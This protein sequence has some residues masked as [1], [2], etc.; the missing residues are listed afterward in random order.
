[1]SLRIFAVLSVLLLGL[2]GQAA[3][4]PTSQ[5]AALRNPSGSLGIIEVASLEPGRFRSLPSGTLTAGFTRDTS[6]LRLTLRAP[7][8]EW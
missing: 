4:P 2:Q 8:G 7:P 1:M 5:L 3:M 6:W